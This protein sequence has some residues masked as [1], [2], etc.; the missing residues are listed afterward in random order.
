MVL[1]YKELTAEGEHDSAGGG[2]VPF[3]IS[4]YLTE[5]DP[6]KSMPTI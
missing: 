6:A 5:M 2:D 3:D 1:R 4:G